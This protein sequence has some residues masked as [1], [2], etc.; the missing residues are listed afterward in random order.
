MI[1]ANNLRVFVGSTRD[2]EVLQLTRLWQPPVVAFR[3]STT[4]G[5][6]VLSFTPSTLR[7][8]S[9]AI[10]GN[11]LPLNPQANRALQL[12]RLSTS[13]LSLTMGKVPALFVTLITIVLRIEIGIDHIF[14]SPA[15]RGFQKCDWFLP[16]RVVLGEAGRGDRSNSK[17]STAS[18][19][20]V[21]SPTNAV[22]HQKKIVENKPG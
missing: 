4:I 5:C 22:S 19:R 10:L 1:Q 15:L 2:R 6:S 7:Q 3:V 12:L 11:S 18:M 13:M 14:E 16:Q 17:K 20:V 21:Q 9:I 8:E